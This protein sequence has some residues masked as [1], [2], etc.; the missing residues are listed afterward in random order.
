MLCALRLHPLLTRVGTRGQLDVDGVA[1]AARFPEL[2]P[3]SFNAEHEEGRLSELRG[4][5]EGPVR[6]GGDGWFVHGFAARAL[7]REGSCGVW[8]AP[9]PSACL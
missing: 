7:Y 3:F 1:T 2:G 9:M 8:Q 5:A 4:C 6:G